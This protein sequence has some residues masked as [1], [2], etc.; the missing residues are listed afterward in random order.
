M[1]T[2]ANFDAPMS[3]ETAY[4]VSRLTPH[5]NVEGRKRTEILSTL[6]I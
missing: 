1:F 4:S 5:N 2:C 3:E 6:F